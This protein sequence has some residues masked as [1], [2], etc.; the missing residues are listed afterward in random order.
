MNAHLASRLRGL[1]LRI[2]QACVDQARQVNFSIIWWSFFNEPPCDHGI[3]RVEA[4]IVRTV[5]QSID[6]GDLFDAIPASGEVSDEQLVDLCA[7]TYIKILIDQRAR[8]VVESITPE[9][10]FCDRPVIPANAELIEKSL[11]ITATGLGGYVEGFEGS[12]AAMLRQAPRPWLA[13]PFVK[14]REIFYFRGREHELKGSMEIAMD[15]G[16]RDILR[17]ARVITFSGLSYATIL[18]RGIKKEKGLFAFVGG[19]LPMELDGLPVAPGISGESF[20]A[21][22]GFIFGGDGVLYVMDCGPKTSAPEA[23]IKL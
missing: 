1:D 7:D 13:M 3:S 18:F 15:Q 16:I 4:E 14:V 22:Y 6:S 12:L 2:A 17:E 19:H 8:R 5:L 11:P 21:K 23:L 9:T 20:T 10:M